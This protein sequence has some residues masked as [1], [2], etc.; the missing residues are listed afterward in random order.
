MRAANKIQ[1]Y[2]T[3]AVRMSGERELGMWPKRLSNKLQLKTRAS[4]SALLANQTC[5]DNLSLSPSLCQCKGNT[6]TAGHVRKDMKDMAL[7][8]KTRVRFNNYNKGNKNKSN[9]KCSQKFIPKKRKKKHSIWRRVLLR[10]YV[11]AI[12]KLLMCACVCRRMCVCVYVY[13]MAWACASVNVA[14]MF[15]Q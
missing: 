4:K 15:L 11:T 14:K 9:Y 5:P 8:Y 10:F 12:K 13:K 7:F 2:S 1:D 3:L 6:H